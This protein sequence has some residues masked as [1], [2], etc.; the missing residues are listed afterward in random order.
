MT[1]AEKLTFH[2]SVGL[3]AAIGGASLLA[4]TWTILSEGAL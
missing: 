4:I 1:K 3:P 2:L